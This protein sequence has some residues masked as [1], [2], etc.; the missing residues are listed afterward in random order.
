MIPNLI[1]GRWE[2]PNVKTQSVY[3]PATGEVIGEVPL[4]GPEQIDAAVRAAAAAYPEWSTTPVMERTRLMF[5]F[6]ALLEDHFE[7]IAAE[8][9][10]H[11][12]LIHI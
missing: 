9:T 3:N 2:R 6:K 5:R 8:V 11:L 4:S 1:G 7:E 10:L 12:S